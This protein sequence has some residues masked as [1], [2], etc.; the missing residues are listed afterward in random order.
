MNFEQ[1]TIDAATAY[2]RAVRRALEP[3]SIWPRDESWERGGEALRTRVRAIAWGGLDSEEL[4]AL[5]RIAG[6]PF[7][8][9]L[10]EWM[11]GFDVQLV[12]PRGAETVRVS[13]GG[14][15]YNCLTAEGWTQTLRG[16][17]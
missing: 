6:H 7:A 17:I 10:P 2:V 14:R 11:L 9:E 13:F 3:A 12:A 15:D 5:A 16:W 8:P 4:N 1:A